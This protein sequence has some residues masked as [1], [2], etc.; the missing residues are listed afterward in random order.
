M[1][2]SPS[3]QEHG[4]YDFLA[5][6]NT[7]STK[8]N[9][10]NHASFLANVEL[11]DRPG[12]GR[13]VFA[14]KDL[15]A[16]DLVICEKAFLV[17]FFSDDVAEVYTLLDLNTNTGVMGTQATLLFGLT[18]K[19]LHNPTAATAFCDL[20]DGT[21]SSKPKMMQVDGM[22]AVEHLPSRCN[23]VLQRL[24]LPQHQLDREAESL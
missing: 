20:Y 13:G 18:Q 3:E 14:T 22:N 12:K 16:G 5:V 2:T 1:L 6:S 11:R 9:R 17:T 21:S 23:P 8:H 4:K 15:K 7:V 24:G 19:L 10:L